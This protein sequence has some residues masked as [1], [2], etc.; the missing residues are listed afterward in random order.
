MQFPLMPVDTPDGVFV[1][2]SFFC[3]AVQRNEGPPLSL[4]EGLIIPKLEGPFALYGE[5]RLSWSDARLLEAVTPER[6]LW[7]CAEL[8][9][10]APPGE[11]PREYLEM[12]LQKARPELLSTD[13]ALTSMTDFFALN[14]LVQLLARSPGPA[15]VQALL[16]DEP[17]AFK[18]GEVRLSQLAPPD[19]SATL[20]RY[21]KALVFRKF[22]LQR[23]PI[24]ENLVLLH[25][26]AALLPLVEACG[27]N[28]LDVLERDLVTHALNAPVHRLLPAFAQAYVEQVSAAG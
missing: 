11:I 8:G 18:S 17:V 9:G 3:T 10:M 23:R 13:E 28:G 14:M 7:A 19:C 22:L 16:Q 6:A 4:P 1:G 2:V 24:L 25:L 15:A 21:R 12:A 26:V 5:A 20:E 27:E